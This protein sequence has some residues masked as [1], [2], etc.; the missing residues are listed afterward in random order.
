MKNFLRLTTSLLFSVSITQ[1]A[2]ANQATEFL[3]QFCNYTP[4][5]YTV[6]YHLDNPSVQQT[7]KLPPPGS[8]TSPC[9]GVVVSNQAT[10]PASIFYLD[11]IRDTTNPSNIVETTGEFNSSMTITIGTD[12]S[13]KV[14]VIKQP[15]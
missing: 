3:V 7:I 4:D 15:K 9:F 11:S 1:L 13:G 5:W 10:P 12:S 2:F 8:G 14:R 6:S